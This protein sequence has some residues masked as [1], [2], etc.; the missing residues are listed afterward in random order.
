MFVV[1][2]KILFLKNYENHNLDTRQR[3]NLYL[4]QANLTIHQTGAYYSGIKMVNNLLTTLMLVWTVE[5]SRWLILVWRVM[6][7][8]LAILATYSVLK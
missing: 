3:N 2:N 1:Q 7:L 6:S 5:F 4:P 8:L